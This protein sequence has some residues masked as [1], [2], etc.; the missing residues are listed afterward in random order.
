MTKP[1]LRGGGYFLMVLAGWAVGRQLHGVGPEAH[2]AERLPLSDEVRQSQPTAGPVQRQETGASKA[3]DG[4]AAGLELKAA[5]SEA[6]FRDRARQ[7]ALEPPPA[8][9]DFLAAVTDSETVRKALLE[10]AVVWA[11]CR[12][13]EKG[14]ALLTSLKDRAE[15]A[16][17]TA[18]AMRFF[19]PKDL[20]VVMEWFHQQ[21]EG[22]LKSA[23]R[24]QI[25]KVLAVREMPVRS[26]ADDART[27]RPV[28][29]F[30]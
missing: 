3:V 12:N 4:T 6:A 18:K 25:I 16:T 14:L 2:G 20:P 10:D 17:L 26:E 9:T 19:P 27:E 5:G 28:H 29:G 22:N 13:P 23:A 11:Y 21:P 24:G 15:I 1:F 8:L 30:S 7:M